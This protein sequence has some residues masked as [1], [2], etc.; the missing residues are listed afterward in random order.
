MSEVPLGVVFGKKV[1]YLPTLDEIGIPFAGHVIISSVLKE[2]RKDYGT[3]VKRGQHIL[4]YQVRLFSKPTKPAI[5]LLRDPI[6]TVT[7]EITSPIAGMYIDSRE[8][9]T[10]DISRHGLQ[11][12]NYRNLLLPI[13]LAPNDEGPA[14]LDNFS[15]YDGIAE[16]LKR[17]WQRLTIR[18]RS[19]LKPDRMADRMR[20]GGA[21]FSNQVHTEAKRLESRRASEYRSYRVEKVSAADKDLIYT[22]QRVQEAYPNLRGYLSHISRKFGE[23]L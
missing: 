2:N 22:V 20:A 19:K 5:W 12:E 9:H 23:K 16:L 18:D 1:L 15:A 6:R 21:D 4:T 7:F 8:E 13:I 3:W 11:Y 14:S 17:N 10:L